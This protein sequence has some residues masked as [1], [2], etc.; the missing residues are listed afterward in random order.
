MK[1]AVVCESC[2]IFSKTVN[3][4]A[5]TCPNNKIKTTYVLERGLPQEDSTVL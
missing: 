1:P 2:F 5:T 3:M 4:P